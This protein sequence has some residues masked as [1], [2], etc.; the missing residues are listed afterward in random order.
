MSKSIH[1]ESAVKNPATDLPPKRDRKGLRPVSPPFSNIS[2]SRFNYLLGLLA[3]V[4]AAFYVWR[5]M[6]WKAEVGGWWN[7]ALGKRPPQLQH[8]DASGAT[9][10]WAGARANANAH[11]FGKDGGSGEVERRIEELAVALGIPSK[12]LANAIAGAVRDH[13]PPASLSS[14]AAHETGE[15]VGHLVDPSG[16]SASEAQSAP[17]ATASRGFWA[18]ESA[19]EA[20]V[21][22]DEPPV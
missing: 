17:G 19:F 1:S 4:I 6:Q 11:G 18:V 10:P 9:A 2:L 8:R 16:A 20:A 5:L 7:L 3:T 22:M 13:V 12:D 21:G 15:A 14:I